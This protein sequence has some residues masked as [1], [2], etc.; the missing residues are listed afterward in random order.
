[1]LTDVGALRIEVPRDREDTF[2]PRRI[3]KHEQLLT[4]F[5]DTIVAM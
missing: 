3:G 2:E 5:D 1:V 4:T